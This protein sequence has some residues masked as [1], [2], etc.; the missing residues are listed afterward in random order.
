MAST[1]MPQR[2]DI[3][4]TNIG[5]AGTGTDLIGMMLAKGKNN[6]PMWVVYDGKHI[7]EQFF[8]GTPSPEY[9][10]PEQEILMGQSDWRSGFGLEYYDSN[11]KRRY[12]SSIG[13]DL[14]FRDMAIA[15]TVP[16]TITVPATT[17]PTMADGGLET[18]TDGNNLTSWSK[19][20]AVLT[21]EAVTI[22]GGTFSARFTGIGYIYQSETVWTTAWQGR[23]FT[24]TAY[25]LTANVND[26][27]IA[28]NDG[29][30]TTYSSYHTGGGAWKQL[31]VSR[32]LDAAATKLEVR[33]YADS[34]IGVGCYFDDATI[35]GTTPGKIVAFAEFNSLLYA[36]QGAVL[37]KM[38]GTGNAFT[39]VYEFA[40]SI[41]DLEPFT[42][43]NLYIALGTSANYYYMSTVEAF[44]ESTAAVKTFQFFK[45]VHSTTPVLWGNDGSNTIRS[46]TN[47]INGGAAWSAQTT[48]GTSYYSI[49]ALIQKAGALYIMKTDMPYYLSSAGAVQNDLAPELASLTSSSSGKNVKLWKNALYIPAGAQT[50]LQTDGTTNTFVS[51][52][53]FCTNLSDFNG[54]VQA[55]AYDDM[56]LFAGLDNS[57]KVEVVAGREETID[58]NTDWRWHPIAEITLGGA[59]CMFVSGVFQKRCYIASTTASDSLYYIPLPT[60]YGNVTADT[61]RKFQTGSYFITPYLHAD[62]RNAMKGFVKLTCTL[63]HAYDVNIYVTASY[64]KLGDTSWTSI[65]NFDGTATNRVETLYIPVDASSNNPKSTMMRFKFTFVTNTTNTTPIL[66]NYTVSAILYPTIRELYYATILCAEEIATKIGILDKNMYDTIKTTLDNARNASWPVSIRD[67]DGDT[68]TVKF[69]PLPN[70]T[71]RYSIIRD[72]KGREQERH[73][74]VIM[75][76][77]PL[78]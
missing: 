35:A 41:T 13:A 38:N 22:H 34:A 14:R 9:T 7:A 56:Y 2:H 3:A 11:D 32:T 67:I 59:E 75:Q 50:L 20:A 5:T 28:I 49:T 77:V 45:T 53:L 66:L 68:Q 18:W 72:D 42:D 57:T 63:G 16:T 26:G 71:P 40:N 61:N 4:I 58:N 55:L 51:P 60:G 31:T 15:G 76:R 25:C 74:N 64:E 69:L 29:V 78:S 52:A 8:T 12:Y 70:S 46:N 1:Y 73:Y 47:P 6:A 54:S 62:F 30:G 23:R 39:T 36:A 19:S 21:R 33:L 27:R 24:L 10:D 17:S 44:T 48:V 37:I 43:N 65:G